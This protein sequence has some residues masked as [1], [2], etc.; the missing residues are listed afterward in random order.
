MTT[1]GEACGLKNEY[2][3]VFDRDYDSNYLYF[4]YADEPEP[5]ITKNGRWGVTNK[6]MGNR[7]D[8][9]TPYTITVVL[10]SEE[11]NQKLLNLKPHNGDYR[12][13][14]LPAGCQ[15]IETVDVTVTWKV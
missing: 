8:K 5:A 10:A 7:G 15:E 4:A 9:N 12:I 1:V 14:D 3:W 6:P 13:R 11:C 2:G